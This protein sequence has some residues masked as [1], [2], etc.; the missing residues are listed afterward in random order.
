MRRALAAL[1]ALF[2]A[3]CSGSGGGW[4]KP[5]ADEA[6]AARAYRDCAALTDTATRTDADID[7]DIA[8]SRASDLQRSS[9]L[10]EHARSTREDNRDRADAILTSCMQAKGFTR[11]AK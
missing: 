4:I 11:N 2:L 8:A 5:G 1:A 10:R 6:A 3:D 9:I 7:Q